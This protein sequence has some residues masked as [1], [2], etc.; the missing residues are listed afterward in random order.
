M[1]T[2]RKRVTAN[3]SAEHY[4]YLL[5]VANSHGM[6]LSWAVSKIIED[7]L[8][9]GHSIGGSRQIKREALNYDPDNK[10]IEKYR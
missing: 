4:N 2:S 9:K 3:L 5:A 8:S 7:H 10:L 1:A 6:T